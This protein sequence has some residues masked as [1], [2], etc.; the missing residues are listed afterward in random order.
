MR[1]LAPAPRR[2]FPWDTSGV[3]HKAVYTPEPTVY[4]WNQPTVFEM[5]L[6]GSLRGRIFRHTSRKPMKSIRWDIKEVSIL[7]GL[8][9]VRGFSASFWQRLGIK[10]H[11]NP[12]RKTAG[13]ANPCIFNWWMH[14][15]LLR[16]NKLLWHSED[17]ELFHSQSSSGCAR[18]LCYHQWPVP[19]SMPR[20]IK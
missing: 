11:E 9:P 6:N 18:L 16:G 15:R 14:R 1:T 13:K 12:N 17:A 4:Q 20:N 5:N 10:W 8:Y 7:S 19:V 3:K 2:P